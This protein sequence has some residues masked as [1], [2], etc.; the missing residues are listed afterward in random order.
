MFRTHPSDY[1][2]L[3]GAR[4]NVTIQRHSTLW[5]VLAGAY[6]YHAHHVAS[7]SPPRGLPDDL[8]FTGRDAFK[9]WERGDQEDSNHDQS[10]A[11]VTDTYYSYLTYEELLHVQQIYSQTQD[12]V[13]QTSRLPTGQNIPANA[14]VLDEHDGW[15]CVEEKVRR[16]NSPHEDLTAILAYLKVYEDAGYQTRII[17]GF[18]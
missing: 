10:T 7:V 15:A 8:S 16:T 6:N 5:A 11:V 9:R 4:Q 18:D 3:G 17:F 13:Y 14:R 1:G 2:V 12:D